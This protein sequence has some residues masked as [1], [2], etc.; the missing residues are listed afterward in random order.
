MKGIIGAIFIGLCLI[1]AAAV[2]VGA[3]SF[4]E[5]IGMVFGWIFW[6][7]AIICIIL[8]VIIIGVFLIICR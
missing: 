2:F 3:L 1:V 4:P 8:A 7:I 5:A 6:I